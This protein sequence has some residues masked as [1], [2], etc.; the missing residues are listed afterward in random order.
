MNN[1]DLHSLYSLG[2]MGFY[3][4]HAPKHSKKVG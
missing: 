4:S 3:V 1:R 2:T